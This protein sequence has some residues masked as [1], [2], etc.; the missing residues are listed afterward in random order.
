MKKVILIVLCLL[1]SLMMRSP[2]AYAAQSITYTD[3]LAVIA[4]Q[5]G[6]SLSS[7]QAHEQAIRRFI[8][9]VINNENFSIISEL[10]HPDYV[11]RSPD[12]EVYGSEG[13]KALFSSYRTAFPDLNIDIDD[14]VVAG[15]KT[16]LSF[17]LT[18]TH[19][20]ELMGIAA[21][22]QPVKVHGIVI[23]RFEE[24]KIVEEWEI[25][26][27]LTMFQQIGIVSLPA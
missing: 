27:L 15:D 5:T 21:T 26:D 7:S 22:N 16:V 20:G 13:L 23:S 3:R 17:T 11:H 18:G 14:L 8:K 9:E 10:I 1:V 6:G 25:V 19:K 24:D 2:Q 4:E 12:G